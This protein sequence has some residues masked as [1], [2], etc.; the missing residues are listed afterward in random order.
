[1]IIKTKKKEEPK[2]DKK[3]RI[4]YRCMGHRARTEDETEVGR[5]A[6]TDLTYG[7]NIEDL[8]ERMLEIHIEAK[9]AKH[10]LDEIKEAELGKLISYWNMWTNAYTNDCNF[11]VTDLI[12]EATSKVEPGEDTIA[13]CTKC[14]QEHRCG[15]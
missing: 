1:M 8:R 12:E 2:I 3:N 15:R 6:I 4:K 14:G 10:I 11:D 13:I 9:F 7:R 5:Q